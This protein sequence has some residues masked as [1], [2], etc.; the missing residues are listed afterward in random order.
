MQLCHKISLKEGVFWEQSCFR[1][2]HFTPTFLCSCSTNP[3]HPR[4]WMGME[5]TP[6]QSLVMICQIPALNPPLGL[7]PN[8]L[9]VITSR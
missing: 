5:I 9:Q 3:A 7:P 8:I 4:L 1:L 6:P 2:T